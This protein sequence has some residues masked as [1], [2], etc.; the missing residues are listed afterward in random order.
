MKKKR[1][2][3]WGRNTTTIP[4]PEITPSTTRLLSA[5]SG[6]AA[7]TR[8]P[9]AANR[10]STRSMSGRAPTKID[11]K[12]MSIMTAKRASPKTRWV[13]TRSMRS[14]QPVRVPPS[15]EMQPWM[16]SRTHW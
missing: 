14:L 12:T 6:S 1:I 7:P 13:A 4:T 8:L 16:R 11:S 3:I 2:T 5:P 9:A 10:D 15:R